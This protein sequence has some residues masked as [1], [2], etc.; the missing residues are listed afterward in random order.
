VKES[1]LRKYI[2][3]EVLRENF[4]GG[5]YMD[6]SDLAAVWG[7]IVDAFDMVKVSFKDVLSSTTY[8]YDVFTA[9]NLQAIEEAHK[10]YE[11]RKERIADEYAIAFRKVSENMGNDFRAAVFLMSPGYYLGSKIAME[12]PAYYKAVVE[13]LR[14]SGIYVKEDM[15]RYSHDSP[16]YAKMLARAQEDSLMGK[17]TQFGNNVEFKR[18]AD[19]II[20]KLDIKTGTSGA[21]E[22]V[23]SDLPII[24][25]RGEKEQVKKSGAILAF[26]D[27]T[28]T[29]E[30]LEPG[31]LIEASVAKDY[32]DLK[33]KEAEDYVGMI[34]MHLQF[35]AEVTASKDIQQLQKA[36]KKMHGGAIKIEGLGDDEVKKIKAAASEIVK[37]AKSKG[38][39]ADIFK[40]AGMKP[41]REEKE[42][43]HE[44]DPPETKQDKGYDSYLEQ[45]AMK[46]AVMDAVRKFTL[47]FQ[48][49]EKAGEAGE[50]Y[51]MQLQAV[52]KKFVD[53]YTSDISKGDIAILEKS[54]NGKKLI[55]A[56]KKGKEAIENA[57]LLE[58]SSSK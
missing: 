38:K 32:L 25:E 43:L 21:N 2:R 3:K 58:R 15:Q 46:V 28:K 49:P 10:D 6:A 20:H 39:T 52:R 53:A 54:P 23:R 41:P 35:I 47:V 24:V 48:D 55:S 1:Q 18:F 11:A 13:Y 17:T 22:S 7:S 36:I 31:K 9:P 56:M 8:A 40:T 51:I 14:E 45:A 4:G 34:N 26:E 37:S 12:G 16:H 29:L 30:E 27:L 44:D 42:Q 19:R 50:K 5:V 57:G 33:K